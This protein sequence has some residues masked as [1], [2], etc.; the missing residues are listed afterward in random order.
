ML[1]SIRATFR[2]RYNFRAASA[3]SVFGHNDLTVDPLLQFRNMRNDSDEPIAL[4][5]TD[6]RIQRLLQRFLIER[7]EA[8]IHKHRIQT[9]ASRGRLNFI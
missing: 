2:L 6:Q 5:Q 9:D 8:L 7:A 4:R 3:G 1:H